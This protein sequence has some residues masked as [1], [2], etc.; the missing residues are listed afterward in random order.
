MKFISYFNANPLGSSEK[1]INN[2]F[3][4]IFLTMIARLHLHNYWNTLSANT[5]NTF[6]KFLQELYDARRDTLYNS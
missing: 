1:N 2:P 3:T 6:A 5:I 4:V